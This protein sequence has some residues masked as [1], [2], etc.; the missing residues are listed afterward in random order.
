MLPTNLPH[1]EAL[2][3]QGT[4][5]RPI[6][7]FYGTR[8]YT[9]RELS[10]LERL[11]TDASKAIGRELS[12]TERKVL[13]EYK[14][15]LIASQSRWKV[16][17]FDAGICAGVGIGW[18]TPRIN[19]LYQKDRYVRWV[20]GLFWRA[21]LGAYVALG[22]VNNYARYLEQ[23]PLLAIQV[24]RDPRM[25]DFLESI[26]RRKEEFGGHEPIL[27]RSWKE[28]K[29]PEPPIQWF[30]HI[31]GHSRQGPFDRPPITSHPELSWFRAWPSEC[32]GEESDDEFVASQ[33]Q[34][35]GRRRS[36]LLD[37]KARM[38]Q[39]MDGVRG[40]TF[41]HHIADLGLKPCMYV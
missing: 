12:T 22:A 20:Y 41:R 9:S 31:F 24:V 15:R 38:K 5:R 4:V 33:G 40:S 36:E 18:F 37:N 30:E 3:Q 10:T 14:A 26:M 16:L 35:L 2:I 29:N 17:G 23:S 7:D 32:Q 21:A 19:R 28:L 6:D 1:L 39:L 25:S 34:G 13:L 27:V 11:E 8:D